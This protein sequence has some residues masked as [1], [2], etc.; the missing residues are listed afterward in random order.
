VHR[1]GRTWRAGVARVVN[2]V[3]ERDIWCKNRLVYSSKL[4]LV[5]VALVAPLEHSASIRAHRT[6]SAA[7]RVYT[8]MR[9]RNRRAAWVA[10]SA[11]GRDR[12][13][14]VAVLLGD[15]AGNGIRTRDFDLGK[16]ALYH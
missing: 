3:R 8:E 7:R 1:G 12:S 5:R 14:D 11:T 4:E 9:F 2:S 15:G 13:Y 6:R 16:V 10:A